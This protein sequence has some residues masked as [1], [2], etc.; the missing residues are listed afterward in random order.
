MINFKKWSAGS[1]ASDRVGLVV[2]VISLISTTFICSVLFVSCAQSAEEKEY[3]KA[4][5]EVADSVSTYMKGLATD[6]I[7]G[8]T[9]NFIRKADVRFK[10]RDVL[11]ASKKIEDITGSSGG[12]V[13]SS[14]LASNTQYSNSTRISKDSVLEQVYYTMVNRLYLRVPASQLDTVLRRISDLA[15]FIDYRN[16]HS[17]D[18]K[19]KL[20]SNKLTE[21]RYKNFKQSVE[22]KVSTT[23]AKQ[24]EA[25]NTE[26]SL[27][28]K[29]LL[30]DQKKIESFELADQVNYS[31]ITL[32][33]YQPA[34]YMKQYLAVDEKI[35]AY[36]PSFFEKAGEGFSNGFSILKNFLLFLINSWA[37]ILII[38]TIYFLIRRIV[39]RN[40]A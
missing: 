4:N 28:N 24:S 40:R 29:Q 31:T 9:H 11:A 16:M 13:S 3:A 39:A 36:E 32:E 7:N 30:A 1:K 20:F 26:E 15:V 19:M 10:V 5:Q 33:V 34:S 23:P 17:D 14:E 2:P 8:V 35:E 22:K 38:V 6:T 37:V 12:Y 18:V 25:L 21:D 27:L